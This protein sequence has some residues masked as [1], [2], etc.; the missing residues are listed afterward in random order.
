MSSNYSKTTLYKQPQTTNSTTISWPNRPKIRLRRRGRRLPS[1]Q[2]GGKKP[3]RGFFLARFI[4]RIRLRWQKIHYSCML[5]KLKMY[6]KSLIKDLIEA[7]A[8]VESYQQRVLM[9]TSFAVPVVGVS[10]CS[11]PS[12][13]AMANPRS[14]IM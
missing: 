12:A 1:I 4:R 3:R 14:I 11:Y 9:E 7:N 13:A 6:Y 2:L 5:R 8:S 10:F